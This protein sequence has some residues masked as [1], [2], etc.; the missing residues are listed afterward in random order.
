MTRLTP[1]DGISRRR[2]LGMLAGP[3]ALKD[4]S[5]SGVTVT[6][7]ANYGVMISNG[8]QAVV[9]DGLFREGI[10][11]YKR[12]PAEELSKLEAGEAPYDKVE[13]LLVSHLHKDHFSEKSVASLLDARRTV[14]LWSSPQVCGAVLEAMARPQTQVVQTIP[15]PGSRMTRRFGDL[16]VTM[17]R[18]EHGRGRED[19]Q[20][21]GHLIRIGGLTFLHIGDAAAPFDHLM[22]ANLDRERI[23]V[24]LLPWW[25]LAD[26]E[27]SELIRTKLNPKTIIAMHVSPEDE[28][29]GLPRITGQWPDLRMATQ[30]MESWRF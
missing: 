17:F 20:N 28:R 1:H 29:K 23:D 15:Q 2:A 18:V 7:L 12:V 24:A 4:G 16:Q 9:V 3:L 19:I 27:A 11:P 5:V 22:A 26:A 13:L 10:P 6:H 14:Q 21:L 30:P 8:H 25:L